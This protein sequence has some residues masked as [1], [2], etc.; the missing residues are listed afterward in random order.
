MVLALVSKL[1]L[2]QW[3]TRMMA[4]IGG[5]AAIVAG[6]G[7]GLFEAKE[8]PIPPSLPVGQP[9]AAGE[10]SLR[11]DR[12]S[13]SDRL[14][15]G[16][17]IARFGRKAIVLELQATNR[18]ARTSSSFLRAVKLTTPIK[19]IDP[20][21]T[22]YLVRDR[23]MTIE[24]QPG[25]PE[26]IALVWTYPAA[27]RTAARLRFD[28]TANTFKPFDNLYAQP[29]WTDPHPAGFIDLRLVAA[30]SDASAGAL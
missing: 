2:G 1:S 26:K 18:T 25:L 22:A 28:V 16:D 8:K 19:G 17:V 20:L 15:N 4:G 24:L 12:V 14:P 30:S 21:P 11:F 13:L 7:I 3:R 6:W 23:E 9:I 29:I 27:E 5:L 10:W